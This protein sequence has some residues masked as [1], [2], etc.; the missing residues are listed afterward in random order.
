[1]VLTLL[2]SCCSCGK[3][4]SPQSDG[5]LRIIASIFPIYDWTENIAE[6]AKVEC[7][8]GSGADSH[9][10]EPTVNDIAEI[11]KA[12][13][14]I[15]VGGESENWVDSAVEASKNEN[16]TV[17]KLIN[18]VNN[19]KEDAV[20]PQTDSEDAYDEHIWLS[21]KNA[22]ICVK[23]IADAISKVD[24][25]NSEKYNENAGVYVKKLD[26]LDKKYR[27]TIENS[28]RK[29]LI[30][31]DRYP[32]RYM[33]HDYGIECFAAFA[34]CS[35]ESQAEFK[36]VAFLIEKV[37]ETSAP[38]VIKIDGSNGLI[39]EMVKDETNSDILTLNSCQSVTK[40]EISEGAN[41]I[42]IMSDNLAALQKALY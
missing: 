25:K 26:D 28:K 11:S 41:Y 22:K 19:L 16:L 33:A 2:F 4:Y 12:D 5:E 30:F 17:I 36:T 8:G 27:E 39:A 15:C 32:F 10:F 14:F 35:S 21:L 38:Y 13:V 18:N 29:T 37:R 20:N 42:N 7:L 31:A 34:G 9:S 23:E 24:S 40:S 6:N 1:M 3:S